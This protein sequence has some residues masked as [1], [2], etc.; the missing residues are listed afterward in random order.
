M[1]MQTS[2]RR[3]RILLGLAAAV[4]FA[5]VAGVQAHEG[6]FVW[7]GT[8]TNGK[9]GSEG[10][11]VSRFDAASGKLSDPQLAGTAKNP[12]FLAAH[13]KLPVLY[14]VSE[15]A[16]ADGKPMG[17]VIAFRIDPQNGRLSRLNHQP[18]GGKGPCHVSVD[19]SGSVVLAAN[20]GSGSVICLGIAADGSLEPVVAGKKGGFLQHSGSGPNPGRQAGPHGHS[21]DPT[22][23]GRFAISC[24]LGIDKVLVHALDTRHATLTPHGFGAVPAG[25]GPRHLALHPTQPFA[26]CNNELDMTVT[27][28]ALDP[29]AGRLEPIQTLSTLPPEV[30]DHTGFSTAEIAV[31]PDGRT[32]YVSNRGHHSIAIFAV[33]TMTGRL[34]LQKTEPI[35]GRTPRS[36]GIHPGGRFLLAAGQDSGTVSVFGIDPTTGLLAFQEPTIT[37]PSPVCVCYAHT[38]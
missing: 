6:S 16:D 8:Y 21:I 19:R 5:G 36:F 37:V 28:F 30:T 33:D 13:P 26:Y 27:A 17:A 25:A 29:A 10:I 2:R 34:T 23:D 24:D 9:T 22:P 31:H 38:P 7:F 12:S 1:R 14:A 4:W 32:V 20:Y 15:V 35:R 11:Y 3:G 18:S